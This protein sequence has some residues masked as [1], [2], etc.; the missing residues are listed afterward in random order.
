MAKY[1]E[2]KPNQFKFLET[3]VFPYTVIIFHS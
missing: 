3:N 1:N 2:Q